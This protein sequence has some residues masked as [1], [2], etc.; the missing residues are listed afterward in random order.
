MSKALRVGAAPFSSHTSA[1]TSQMRTSAP[2]ASFTRMSQNL[3]IDSTS[4]FRSIPV[5][6]GTDTGMTILQ[7]MPV[8]SATGRRRLH[9]FTHNPA[10]FAVCGAEATGLEATVAGGATRRVVSFGGLYP[11]NGSR[12]QGFRPRPHRRGL[13]PPPETGAAETGGL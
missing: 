4:G 3:A 13:T 6:M 9:P 2:I 10:R 11:E 1:A 7:G 5:Q 12:G 8:V